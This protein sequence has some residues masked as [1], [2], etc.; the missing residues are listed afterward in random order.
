MAKYNLGEAE[1]LKALDDFWSEEDLAKAIENLI[2]AEECKSMKNT[3]IEA[4]DLIIP[5]KYCFD[6]NHKLYTPKTYPKDSL[7]TPEVFTVVDFETGYGIVD[8]KESSL[9]DS[10]DYRSDNG[11]DM[12]GWYSTEKAAQVAFNDAFGENN[13]VI[14]KKCGID[15]YI[16][17]MIYEL[18]K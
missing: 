6:T 7:G 18:H 2:T 13:Y 16:F 3:T 4:G 8:L 12:G 1:M 14:I 9:L 5:N 17:A 15:K 11:A 10:Y